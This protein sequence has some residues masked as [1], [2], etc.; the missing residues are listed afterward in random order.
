MKHI[1][2][3]VECIDFKTLLNVKRNEN[4][5]VALISIDGQ[6]KTQRFKNDHGNPIE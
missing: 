2:F 5:L 6:I 3:D 4:I 1:H